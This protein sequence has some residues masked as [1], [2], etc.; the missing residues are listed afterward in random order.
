MEDGWKMDEVAVVE[1]CVSEGDVVVE[2]CS[3]DF[4]PPALARFG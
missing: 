4:S 2:S 3:R 1:R